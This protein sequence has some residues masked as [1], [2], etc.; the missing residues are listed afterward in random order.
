VHAIAV[1]LLV[2]AGAWLWHA[3]DRNS[4]YSRGPF[5]ILALQVAVFSLPPFNQWMGRQI[6]R[7]TAP[8]PRTRTVISFAIGIVAGLYLLASA[9]EQ[10]RDFFPKFHD[11]YMHLIQARLLSHGRLWGPPHALP[12]FFETF[13]VFVTPVYAGQHFPG[14]AMIYVPG[15]WLGL[16]WWLTSLAVSG[17]AV[18]L[19]YRVVAEM[20]DGVAGILAALM[21]LGTLEFRYV[22]L[23]ALSNPIAL[24][25][26][27]SMVWAWLRWREDHRLRW[28]LVLGAFSGWAAITRP[29][30]AIC[31]AI[32]IGA[33]IL[34]ELW[35]NE[36]VRQWHPFLSTS[37]AIVAGAIPFLLLQLVFDRGVTGQWLKTP[38]QYYGDIFYPGVT[39]GLHEPKLDRRPATSLPQKLDYY[40]GFLVENMRRYTPRTAWEQWRE[41]RFPMTLKSSL[42]SPLM[43]FLLPAGLLGLPA[44]RRWVLALVLPLFVLLYAP[45]TMFGSVYGLLVAV[46]TIPLAILGSREVEAA[47]EHMLPAL[48]RRMRPILTIMLAGIS[49]AALP[50]FSPSTEQYSAPTLRAVERSLNGIHGRALVFFRYKTGQ[51]IHE[52]PV[53]NIESADI[54]SSRIVRAQDLGTPENL[55]LIRYYAERQPDRQV[56]RFDRADRTLTQLGSVN[57]LAT[58]GGVP[59]PADG[60]P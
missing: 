45:N 35:R 21:L 52:E 42:P 10:H 5:L 9:L 55:K 14:A 15:M 7:L 4:W 36:K 25:F 29:P 20:I 37:G 18:G 8:T 28:V 6:D 50:Q 58:G 48:R 16:P 41:Q 43:I 11:E 32:P 23:M 46:A 51:N 34:I 57:S 56:Y 24:L 12:Q 30:D 60:E 59:K 1:L 13:H 39:Y 17:S 2:A 33:A 3:F 38:H 27:L 44:K 47:I 49:L 22:S 26:G 19:I 31:F 54:D 53:Y 40:D